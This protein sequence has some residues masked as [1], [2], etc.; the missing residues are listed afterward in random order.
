MYEIRQRA[1][2]QYC[3]ARTFWR[4]RLS[5]A[6]LMVRSARRFL[7][8]RMRAWMFRVAEAT[9]LASWVSNHASPMTVRQAVRPTRRISPN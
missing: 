3:D 8:R 5:R 4:G 6:L 1:V 9:E 7:R 2:R